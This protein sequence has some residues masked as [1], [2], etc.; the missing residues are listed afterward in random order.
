MISD[1]QHRNQAHGPLPAHILEDPRALG[2]HGAQDRPAEAHDFLLSLCVQGVGAGTPMETPRQNRLGVERLQG[3]ASSLQRPFGDPS[4][5]HAHRQDEASH[6]QHGE[7]GHAKAPY[8]KQER[9]LRLKILPEGLHG[10]QLAP[11]T[12]AVMRAFRAAVASCLTFTTSRRA[13]DPTLATAS[14]G[15][16]IDPDVVV[17]RMTALRRCMAR[18]TGMAKMA[19]DFM[20]QYGANEGRYITP[21]TRT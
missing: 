11:L 9:I 2:G 4:V 17:C 12:E 15:T 19:D 18:A 7:M 13:T 8:D 6:G 5:D 1:H 10:C 16:D 14:R 20:E 21:T 3:P